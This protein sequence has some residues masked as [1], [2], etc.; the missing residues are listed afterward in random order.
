M[1]TR[2]VWLWALLPALALAAGN[3]PASSSAGEAAAP[4]TV[5]IN[6][7]KDAIKPTPAQTAA[8]RRAAAE[9]IKEFNHP[10]QGGYAVALADLND[11]GRSG[12]LVQYDDMA[13]CGSSGCSGVIVLATP[14]GYAGEG[15]GLPNFTTLAV[16]SAVH[17]GMHD[18]QYNGNSPIWKWNGKEYDVPGS[19]P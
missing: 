4:A 10:E 12:L 15:I 11:D 19:M 5:K 1:Q 2:N 14:H 13:F 16:L 3:A 17:H 9:D 6:F 18:L 7:G 8:I